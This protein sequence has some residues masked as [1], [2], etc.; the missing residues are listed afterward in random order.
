MMMYPVYYSSGGGGSDPN[1]YVFKSADQTN[2][3]AIFADVTGMGFSLLASTNYEFEYNLIMDADAVGTGMDISVNGPAGFTSLN[4]TIGYWTSATVI[5]F[6]PVSTYDN[7]TANTA[8][9]GAT[10]AIFT[11]KGI[12]RNGLVAGTLI[13]RVK[14]EAVGSGPNVRIGSWGKIRQI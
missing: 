7:N 6:R 5:A 13:P 4:Y 11:V 8:S 14:R 1:T 10:R 9:N 12:V 2:I 3:G